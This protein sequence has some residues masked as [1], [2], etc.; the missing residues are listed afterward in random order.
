MF[1]MFFQVARAGLA[2]SFSQTELAGM[3]QGNFHVMHGRV[4]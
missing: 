2:T 3:F 4:F 1:T